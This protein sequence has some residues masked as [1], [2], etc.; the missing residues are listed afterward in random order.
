MAFSL[1]PNFYTSYPWPSGTQQMDA[2]LSHN[3]M[4]AVQLPEWLVSS[5]EARPGVWTATDRAYA[6]LCVY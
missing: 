2:R 3:P 1:S 5:L 4:T 6:G